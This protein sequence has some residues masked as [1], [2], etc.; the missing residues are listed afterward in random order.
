[1]EL[2]EF[3]KLIAC[4]ST[5]TAKNTMS[6]LIGNSITNDDWRKALANLY[7]SFPKEL[8]E[9]NEA[10]KEFLPVIL[11]YLY[12]FK[13][14]K[15]NIDIFE[16]YMDFISA[17]DKDKIKLCNPHWVWDKEPE[18]N[19]KN[20]L[21]FSRAIKK[22]ILYPTPFDFIDK[23]ENQFEFF[24]KNKK[25]NIYQNFNK[26]LIWIN[27]IKNDYV[28][29]VNLC[30]KYDFNHLEILKNNFGENIR[31]SYLE[32]IK[33]NSIDFFLNDLNSIGKEFLKEKMPKMFPKILNKN[34]FSENCF[35]TLIIA[36]QEKQYIAALKYMNFFKQELNDCINLVN[37]KKEDK[38]L[39]LNS[40]REFEETIKKHIKY[41]GEDFFGLNYRA[42]KLRGVLKDDLWF[43][44]LDKYNLKNEL[45]TNLIVE[46]KKE[47]KRKVKL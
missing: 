39:T 3:A 22:N 38:C 45:N 14:S 21:E 28:K 41:I 33:D 36:I 13:I 18:V 15:E 44:F 20:T 46:E 30:K 47:F 6:Y 34:E 10:K 27:M 29:Y 7:R 31:L 12:I 24:V 8:K 9:G 23:Y 43:S 5:T 11:K 40:A 4:G 26:N 25:D 16:E 35:D 1:M 37:Y 32:V 42:S 17:K 19:F 2:T